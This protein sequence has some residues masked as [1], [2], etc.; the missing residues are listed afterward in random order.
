MSVVAKQMHGS[1][2]RRNHEIGKSIGHNS[3]QSCTHSRVLSSLEVKFEDIV[4]QYIL[5]FSISFMKK[6]KSLGHA[7]Y[8]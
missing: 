2:I 1:I 4:K 7:P 5:P 8:T 3:I 6:K